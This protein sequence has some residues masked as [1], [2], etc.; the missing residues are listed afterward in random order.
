MAPSASVDLYQTTGSS[1]PATAAEA[2]AI[3]QAIAD[4]AEHLWQLLK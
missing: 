3:G 1:P 2:H 4:G